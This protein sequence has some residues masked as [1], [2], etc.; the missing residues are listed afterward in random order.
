M[1]VRCMMVQRV[2][3]LT[4]KSFLICLEK[5]W[6]LMPRLMSLKEK[7]TVKSKRCSWILSHRAMRQK[8]S[9]SMKSREAKFNVYSTSKFLTQNGVTT[10]MRWM[11]SKQVLGYEDITKKTLSPSTRK[12]AITSLCN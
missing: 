1:S 10:S 7:I 3:T 9:H 2:K 11:Y 5:K 8:W 12:I 4:L 6:Q